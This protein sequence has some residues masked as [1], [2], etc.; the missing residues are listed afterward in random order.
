MDTSVTST[1]TLSFTATATHV[2]AL[3]FIDEKGTGGDLSEIEIRCECGLLKALI[4]AFEKGRMPSV[5]AAA[6]G[7]GWAKTAMSCVV[8]LTVAPHSTDC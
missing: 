1:G 6:I 5:G 3:C 4:A 8:I 7:F 2:G